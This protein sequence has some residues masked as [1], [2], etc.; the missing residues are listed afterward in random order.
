MVLRATLYLPEQCVKLVL[1]SK[2]GDTIVLW[3]STWSLGS[4][5]HVLKTGL[6]YLCHQSLCSSLDIISHTQTMF[7]PCT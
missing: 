2:H 6:L 4:V 3:G 7:G 1:G 5:V